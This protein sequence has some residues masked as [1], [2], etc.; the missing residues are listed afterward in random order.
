MTPNV[1]LI[2]LIV[3]VVASMAVGFLWYSPLLF[4][5]QWSKLMGFTKESLKKAQQSMGPM[6]GLSALAALVTAFVLTHLIA[7]A[8]KYY[9]MD[10]LTTGVMTA[11]WGWLGLVA[12]VQ[13]T[14]V[15]FGNKKW[16]LFAINTGYQLAS[17]LVMGTII[18]LLG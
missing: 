4:G 10:R 2:A 18:A 7:Q 16:S 15:I 8:E 1:N 14:D 17:L 6:Y 13:M 9:G 11:F 12:P 3:A 5:A